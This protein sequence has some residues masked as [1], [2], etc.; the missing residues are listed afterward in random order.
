MAIN[1]GHCDAEPVT[2][3]LHHNEI[4]WGNAQDD[5]NIE[6]YPE[7][8]KGRG[9]V[10]DDKIWNISRVD[11]PNNQVTLVEMDIETGQTMIVSI[12]QCNIGLC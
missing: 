12:A 6:T 10:I 11:I 9:V 2:N 4:Q 3:F 5:V 8:H 1:T 7:L